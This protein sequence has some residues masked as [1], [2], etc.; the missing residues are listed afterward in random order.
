MLRLSILLGIFL[1]ICSSC[2]SSDHSTVASSEQDQGIDAVVGMDVSVQQTDA[3]HGDSADM[4]ILG[5]RPSRQPTPW[6]DTG[7]GQGNLSQ[8]ISEGHARAGKVELEEELIRG[9]EAN[10]RLG[11]FRMDNEE[12]VICIQGES[13]FSQ[14][15]FFGGNIVD[16]HLVG[17]PGTDAFRELFIAADLGESRVDRIGVVRDGRDGGPAIVRTEGGA[18]GALIFQGVAPN[19]FVPPAAQVVTEY[20]LAPNSNVVQVSTWVHLQEDFAVDFKLVDLLYFGDQTHRFVPGSV[21]GEGPLLMDFVGATAQDVSYGWY[22]DYAPFSFFISVAFDIPGTPTMTE[23]VVMQPDDM[24][25][26]ERTL[27]IGDGDIESIRQSP[28]GREV[29]ISAEP[30]THVAV[31]DDQSR[32][33]TTVMVEEDGNAAI[34][35]ED[36]EY[37]L[38]LWPLESLEQLQSC[39]V[40]EAQNT[41]AFQVPPVGILQLSVTDQNGAPIDVMVRFRGAEDRTDFVFITALD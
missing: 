7:D 40:S 33:V 9:P 11:D 23:N 15:S 35:L 31:L 5:I 22:P 17:R 4:G 19:L 30:S 36:G 16:A 28:Q 25:L 12:I 29:F 10:C 6:R 1:T 41:C 32:L 2:G 37:Q 34:R 13:T 8:P 21:D 20:S 24:L 14:F 3:S 27:V 26:F 38:A 18:Q 39:V